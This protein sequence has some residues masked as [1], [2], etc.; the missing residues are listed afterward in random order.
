MARYGKYTLVIYT[1]FFIINEGYSRLLNTI[2]FHTN[3]YLL[4][5]IIAIIMCIFICMF[6]ICTYNVF[7][8]Y[9]LLKSFFLGVIIDD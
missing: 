6:S 1:L 7:N 8:K 2:N 9:S 5:D 3:D 4:I